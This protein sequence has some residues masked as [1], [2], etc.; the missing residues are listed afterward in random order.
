M[1]VKG[2]RRCPCPRMRSSNVHERQRE[3]AA[4]KGEGP[5]VFKR[6]RESR[7]EEKEVRMR[8]ERGAKVSLLGAWGLLSYLMSGCGE[9]HVRCRACV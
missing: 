1:S 6:K 9:V 2:T 3:F 7:R 5:R 8:G 4:S